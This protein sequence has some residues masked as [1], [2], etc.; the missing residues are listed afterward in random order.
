MFNN[1]A[2]DS[3]QFEFLDG[4][5]IVSFIAQVLNM[6]QNA[7]Q[8]AYV[9]RVMKAI[10]HEINLLHQEN[11]IIMRQNEEILSKLQILE[12]RDSWLWFLQISKNKV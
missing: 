8:D 10:A 3:Q 5:N 6:G 7:D 2:T 9:K 12:E 11:N 4:I 1:N